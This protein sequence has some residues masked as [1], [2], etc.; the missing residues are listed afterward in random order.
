MHRFETTPENFLYP[1]LKP[2]WTF[3]KKV[4]WYAWK[5]LRGVIHFK[6][7]ILRYSTRLH[8]ELQHDT[9]VLRGDWLYKSFWQDSAIDPHSNQDWFKTDYKISALPINFLSHCCGHN[10]YRLIRPWPETRLTFPSH[11]LYRFF[12]STSHLSWSGH[13]GQKPASPDLSV[14]LQILP[15]LHLTSFISLQCRWR[16]NCRSSTQIDE[17]KLKGQKYVLTG[18]GHCNS[19]NISIQMRLLQQEELHNNTS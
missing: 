16:N 8:F 2:I 11:Y 4:D 5:H 19:S 18:S 15:R 17:I 14:S 3:F 7:S 13:H 10:Q 1:V 9:M 12:P 6:V